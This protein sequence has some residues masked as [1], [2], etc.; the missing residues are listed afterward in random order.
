MAASV[1]GA[2]GREGGGRLS[3]TRLPRLALESDSDSLV[4]LSGAYL[5]Y[6][7]IK[8]LNQNPSVIY[9]ATE[10]NMPIFKAVKTAP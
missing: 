10:A 9:V 5:Q 3:G 7:W 2:R 6:L 8:T 4:T 1:D